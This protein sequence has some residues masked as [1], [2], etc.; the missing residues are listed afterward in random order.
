M[1]AREAIDIFNNIPRDLRNVALLVLQ[2]AADDLSKLT[3]K[4]R[5]LLVTMFEQAINDKERKKNHD[6]ANGGAQAAAVQ[7][8][9]SAV[10]SPGEQSDPQT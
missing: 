5:D 1:K 2:A 8:D 10:C 9:V 6:D 7:S 4:E 3:K